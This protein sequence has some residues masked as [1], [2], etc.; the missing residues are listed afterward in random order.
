[1]ARRPSEI[2]ETAI[3]NVELIRERVVQN[4]PEADPDW[5]M[6]EINRVTQMY[7]T[8][9]LEDALDNL[10]ATVRSWTP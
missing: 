2:V 10:S 9:V 4:N 3:A 6:G 7:C 8:L 5:T 1:M